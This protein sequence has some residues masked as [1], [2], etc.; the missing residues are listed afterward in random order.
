MKL[1]KTHWWWG[2]LSLVAILSIWWFFGSQNGDTLTTTT[3]EV[4]TVTA[5]IAVS[6][7]ATVE[8]IIPLSFPKSGT[9]S[10][11]FVARGDL[12]ATGTIL[13]TLG[14]AASQAEYAAALAEVTR[15]KALRD[16]L[17]AGQ[18]TEESAVTATTIQN[19]EEA[20]TATIRT[21]AAQVE[22][23]RTTLYSSGLTAIASDPDAIAPV[24]TITGSY[25]C[26]AEGEYTIELYRS[27]TPSGY[28]YRYRGIETGT[29]NAS[30]N[31]SSPLGDC[32]LRLQFTPNVSYTNSR[33]TIQIPNTTSQT[34]AT[35]RAL[36]EQA[37]AQEASSIDAAKRTYELALNQGAVATAGARVEQLIA[38]NAT[39][40]SAEARLMQVAVALADNAVRAPVSGLITELN[41][42]PGQ[43]VTNSPVM[44]L[45]APKKTTVTARIPEKDVARLVLDQ[46]ATLEFD[47]EPSTTLEGTV[48]FISPLPTTISGIPYYETLID[49]D[50]TPAWLRSGMQADVE[51]ITEEISDAVRIPRL[52]L[53]DGTVQIKQGDQVETLTP[54][55]RLIG[56][57]GFVAVDG[58]PSG[59]ELVLP[60]K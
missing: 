47:A 57:D 27:G 1:I 59:S 53:V 46:R 49:L 4:G 13:A 14:D 41:L 25:T 7:T 2:I 58:I 48:T 19:A 37:L 15:V 42:V 39:V 9:V 3:A 8:D 24:P 50:T 28:S 40:A 6:G 38:A 18:T 11:V 16:E 51:I 56:S 29:G 36:Y 55:I 45:F 32:G 35:N 10:G 30:T 20:L 22:T 60:T 17:L 34:Y 21:A 26:T 54:T 33:F 52:Y 5:F 12:V 43:T 31:Q 44:T 23:A